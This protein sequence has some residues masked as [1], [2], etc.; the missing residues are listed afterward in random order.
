MRGMVAAFAII[1]TIVNDR[2]DCRR[3][4]SPSQRH[5]INPG[6]PSKARGEKCFPSTSISRTHKQADLHSPRQPFPE[7][8]TPRA[9]SAR[10]P[11][12]AYEM[13]V[14]PSPRRKIV[15]GLSVPG[16]GDSIGDC[17]KENRK[18]NELSPSAM[19]NEG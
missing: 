13:V 14:V 8:K 16:N 6:R 12:R 7:R 11:V 3:R 9:V 19:R 17:R 10:K 1:I 5:G 4:R 2:M 18:I 15:P